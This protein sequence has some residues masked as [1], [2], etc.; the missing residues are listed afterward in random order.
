MHSDSVEVLGDFGQ[1]ISISTNISLID[2]KV[3][4]KARFIDYV[5]DINVLATIISSC[6][7]FIAFTVVRIVLMLVTILIRRRIFFLL[8]IDLDRVVPVRVQ[9]ARVAVA[10]RSVAQG[11]DARTG[12]LVHA[13]A[14]IQDGLA[15]VVLVILVAAGVAVIRISFSIGAGFSTSLSFSLSICLG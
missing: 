3:I 5:R 9:V 12:C 1:Q 14:V 4:V 15:V 8:A 6:L 10:Q 2:N 11:I 7:G 13:W